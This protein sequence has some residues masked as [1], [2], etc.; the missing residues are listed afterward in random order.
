MNIGAFIHDL[1]GMLANISHS[2]A[3]ARLRS[4]MDA[5][6]TEEEYNHYAKLSRERANIHNTAMGV[7]GFFRRF[8]GD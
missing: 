7:H 1:F 8:H 2:S 3:Q 4:R 6:D 5:A